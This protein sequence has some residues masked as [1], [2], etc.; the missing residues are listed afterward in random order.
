MEIEM[1]RICW[2][3]NLSNQP[4]LGKSWQVS[5]CFK[6]AYH[7]LTTSFP[8]TVA[9]LARFCPC[10][11]LRPLSTRNRH[12]WRDSEKNSS[13]ENRMQVN[14]W[15]CTLPCATAISKQS[16]GWKA[17]GCG[18]FMSFF[19]GERFACYVFFPWNPNDPTFFWLEFW[20]SFRGFDLQK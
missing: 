15:R 2:F 6:V 4:I 5:I 10:F 7:M 17:S 19:W 20:P 13:S 16:F 8:S 3:Q 18:Q 9:A 1:F 11:F 12:H 14:D